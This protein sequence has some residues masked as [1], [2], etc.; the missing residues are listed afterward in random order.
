MKIHVAKTAEELGAQAAHTIA[1]KL[2]EA[3]AESGEARLVLSTGG[4]QFETLKALLQEDV[5]WD[6]VTAFHLD[7]YIDLPITHAASFRKYLKERFIDHVHLK[8]F[9]FVETEGD[10][11]D[12]IRML[13][14]RLRE[15][16]IDVGVI[17][18]G[19]NAHIAFNDPP[20]DFDTKQAYIIVNLD[21]RCKKQQVGEGWFKDEDEVPRQAV[22]MTPYQIMQC[23]HIISPVPHKVKADA[24][25]KVLSAKTVDPMVPGSLLKTHPD[26]QLFLDEES[27]ANCSEEMLAG[28]GGPRGGGNRFGMEENGCLPDACGTAA[29][30]I[31]GKG[32]RGVGASG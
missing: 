25:K 8:E 28:N 13:T 6:K 29:G 4:S 2:C 14:R 20:A 1:E 30:K 17:G 3:I 16:T 11:D 19:E 9:V 27:A 12:N 22:S 31:P 18:I 7:E 26:F 24:V 21:S 32:R 10:V 5:P 23:A 15:K